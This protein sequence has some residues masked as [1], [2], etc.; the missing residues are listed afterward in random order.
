MKDRLVTLKNYDTMV[1]AMVDLEV[2]KANGIE[3]SINN[4]DAVEILPMFSEINE[5]IRIV[6]FEADLELA[7]S[8]LEEY[9]AEDE[10]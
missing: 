2:L 5:G 7:H 4:E 10:E 8:L 3:C 1:D 9:H 6:V